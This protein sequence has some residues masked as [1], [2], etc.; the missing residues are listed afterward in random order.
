MNRTCSII[1]PHYIPYMGY[2]DLF[3]RSDK[4]IILDDVQFVKREWKNR[5]KI[6]K[7]S[8]IDELKWLSVPVDKKDQK[9]NIT[10]IK[11][12]K[13]NNNWRN[14]HINSIIF[15]YMKTPFFLH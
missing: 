6:R 3:Q 11:I 12:S 15:T 5:N 7:G 2:F 4:I 13:E 9:K 14:Y 8:N 10:D 1:Q